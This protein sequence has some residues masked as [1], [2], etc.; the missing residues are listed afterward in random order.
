[1]GRWLF[2]K[3]AKDPDIILWENL[4]KSQSSKYLRYLISLLLCSALTLLTMI[5]VLSLSYYENLLDSNGS[6]NCPTSAITQDQAYEDF[7]KPI[8]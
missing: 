6:Q 2:V 7:L 1:M 3:K 4:N 5:V 8:D